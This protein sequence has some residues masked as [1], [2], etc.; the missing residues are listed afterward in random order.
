MDIDLN[1]VIVLLGVNG[2]ILC[3]NVR[4]TN[5][6]FTNSGCGAHVNPLLCLFSHN[7]KHLICVS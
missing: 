6:I 1:I 7:A 4:T 3:L 5:S 2:L